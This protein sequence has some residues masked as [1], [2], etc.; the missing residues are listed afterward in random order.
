MALY[1][2][3]VEFDLIPRILDMGL[4]LEWDGTVKVESP[5]PDPR[6]RWIEAKVC[7][8]RLCGLWLHIFFSYFQLVP[9]HCMGCWKIFYAP[10]TIKELFEIHKIQVDSNFD[11][12][13]KCGLE[14]RSITGGIG[15]YRAFWYNPLGCKLE[16]ARANCARVEKLLGGRKVQLKR[17]CTEMEV[18]TRRFFGIGSD[19]WGKLINPKSMDL[20]KLLEETFIPCYEHHINPPL[21][22]RHIKRKWIEFA[23]EHARVTGDTTYKE[24]IEPSS[25]LI[26]VVT[27]LGSIHRSKD[28]ELD[29]PRHC[30]T[31]DG[32]PC[33]CQGEKIC[34]LEAIE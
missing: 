17:G 2:K 28:Y 8:D 12:P 27:Y 31:K 24:L 26:D 3:L 30:D 16:E 32:S 1:E 33:S 21:L 7:E 29:H 13:S 14:L 5:Y 11:L 10:K 19:D 4:R 18:R 9:T 15:G 20:Q 23:M 6:N 25:D 34:K 22:W